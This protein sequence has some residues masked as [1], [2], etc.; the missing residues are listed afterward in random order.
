MM[1]YHLKASEW[2]YIYEELQKIPHIRKQDEASLRIFIEG[3]F[4][5]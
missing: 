5:S 4:L 2:E 3:I 1:D